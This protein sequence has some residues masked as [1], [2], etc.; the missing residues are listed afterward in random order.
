ML[1]AAVTDVLETEWNPCARALEQNEEEDSV[2]CTLARWAPSGVGEGRA[3]VLVSSL[4]ASMCARAYETHHVHGLLSPRS[5][6]WT[7][8]VRLHIEEGH[9]R[10]WRFRPCA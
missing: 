1:M 6:R 8:G 10:V 3:S 5:S 4:C 7:R 2:A 9:R